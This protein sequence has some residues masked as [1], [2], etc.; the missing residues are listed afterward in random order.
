ME[1]SLINL[2][3]ALNAILLAFILVLH[4]RLRR[5][6]ATRYLAGILF[7]AAVVVGLITLEHAEIVW[8]TPFL[9]WFEESLSLLAGPLLL[10]YV[11]QAV[12]AARPPWY[13]FLPWLAH[14]C[15]FLVVG[16]ALRHW[17]WIGQII[18]VQMLYTGVAGGLWIRARRRSGAAAPAHVSLVLLMFVAVHLAQAVRYFWSDVEWLVNIVPWVASAAFFS[19]IAYAIFESRTLAGLA[20]PAVPPEQQARLAALAGRVEWAMNKARPWQDPGL[21]LEALAAAVGYPPAEVSAAL[22]RHLGKTFYDY[23]NAYRVDEAARLL[24]APEERRYSVDG[25]G[26]QAGFGSRSGFY[27]VFKAHTGLSPAEYRRAHLPE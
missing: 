5:S 3:G 9:L 8:P 7:V 1:L 6:A 15:A 12:N 13:A 26:R 22:N 14:L 18:W 11:T 27:K 2:A 20:A 24:S 17:V 19:L 23:V 10:G 16:V 4:P 21:T 25:I